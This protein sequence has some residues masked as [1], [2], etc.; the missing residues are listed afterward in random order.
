[1]L[2]GIIGRLK[3]RGP[4]L[5]IDGPSAFLHVVSIFNRES[6][7]PHVIQEHQQGWEEEDVE[8]ELHAR[9]EAALAA[10]PDLLLWTTEKKTMPTGRIRLY[11]PPRL[12]PELTMSLQQ[13]A[14]RLFKASL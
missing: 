4:P 11:S 14:V 8:P 2:E 7:Y 6:Y 9:R 5:D 1:M 13:A 10:A 12:A 3:G